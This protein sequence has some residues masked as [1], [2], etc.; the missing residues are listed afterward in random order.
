MIR[1]VGGKYRHRNINTPDVDTTKPTKD[2]VREGI[3]SAIGERIINASV[4]DLF[5]GSGALGI[6]ALSRGAKHALFVDNNIKAIQTINENLKK[7]NEENGEVD[8]ANSL[9]I[10]KKLS[11]QK[12]IFDIVFLDPPYKED[13]YQTLIDEFFANGLLSINAIIVCESDKHLNL[14]TDKFEKVKEYS[15]GK[16]KATIFWRKILWK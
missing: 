11:F 2:M 6:E 16:S 8:K 1:I 13:V 9:E 7:L 5:A 12:R 4:L 14:I 15:Y 10:I 3:F